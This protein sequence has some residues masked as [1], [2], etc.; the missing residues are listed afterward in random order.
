MQNSNSLTIVIHIVLCNMYRYSSKES[1]GNFEMHK[2]IN[3]EAFRK[4]NMVS[5]CYISKLIY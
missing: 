5:R 3:I 1:D 2:I 4:L